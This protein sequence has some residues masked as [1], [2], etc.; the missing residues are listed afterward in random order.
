MTSTIRL[1]STIILIGLSETNT[2]GYYT[3]GE[4]S[5]CHRRKTERFTY[6]ELRPLLPAEWGLPQ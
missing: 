3:P 2:I 5:I 1:V 4:C 6:A